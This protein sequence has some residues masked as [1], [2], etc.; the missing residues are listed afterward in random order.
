MKFML[1]KKIMVKRGIS[2]EKLAALTGIPRVALLI[3][4][5]GV[6]EF[7]AWEILNISKALDL[8][9]NEIGE[10]FFKQKFPKGNKTIK[11]S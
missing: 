3:K 1:M 5:W 10:F 11:K 6:V 2:I 8:N 9:K 4:L 7:R